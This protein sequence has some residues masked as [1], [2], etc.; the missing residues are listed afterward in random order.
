MRAQREPRQRRLV[1]RWDSLPAFNSISQGAFALDPLDPLQM[2]FGL[3]PQA[4][5]SG[6]VVV[7]HTLAHAATC[8]HSTTL[9]MNFSL[10]KI[11]GKH[12]GPP[13][14]KLIPNIGVRR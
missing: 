11:K 10:P 3:D 12:C 5:V 14:C 13:Y 4:A 6:R 7:R 1:P 8:G 9:V 2:Q